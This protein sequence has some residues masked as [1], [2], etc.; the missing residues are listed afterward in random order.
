MGIPSPSTEKGHPA[1]IPSTSTGESH[2]PHRKIPPPSGG[3]RGRPNG[4]KGGA[5]QPI[6]KISE[7]SGSHLTIATY[8][9]I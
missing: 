9:V 8:V 3:A 2:P 6:T 1:A 4:D 5:S 7:I